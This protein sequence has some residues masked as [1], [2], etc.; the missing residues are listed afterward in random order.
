MTDGR[1]LFDLS[2]KADKRTLKGQKMK[3]D[4]YTQLV[5]SN[6]I[7]IDLRKQKELDTD[8]IGIQQ[9]DFTGKVC[10]SE[11]TTLFFIIKEAKQNILDFY[12]GSVEVY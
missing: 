1:N 3:G 7:T 2:V 5:E 11:N 12:Q 9:I 6:M 10:Q 8:P 4:D